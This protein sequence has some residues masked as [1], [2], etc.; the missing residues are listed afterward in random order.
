LD[1]D[2]INQLADRIVGHF[3]YV[4]VN[5]ADI[6]RVERQ[7]RE[8]FVCLNLFRFGQLSILYRDNINTWFCDEFELKAL[9][10]EAQELSRNMHKLLQARAIHETLLTFFDRR[11]VELEA[12]KLGAW[13]NPNSLQADRTLAHHSRGADMTSGRSFLDHIY[14]ALGMQPPALERVDAPA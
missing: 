11:K 9:F 5:Y 14:Q 8:I 7:V 12:V 4:Y 13:A 3:P 10:T 6:I 1:T 2:D